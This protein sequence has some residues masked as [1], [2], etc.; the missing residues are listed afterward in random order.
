VFSVWF[1]L[2]NRLARYA[3]SGPPG[4]IQV[5][6]QRFL[7]GLLAA[8]WDA[9]LV[10]MVAIATGAILYDGLSQTQL[11]FDLFSI[12]NLSTS[13]VLLAG[14]LAIIV[15]L[16]LVVGRRVGMVAMGARLLPISVG[17]LIAHYLTYLRVAEPP[18]LVAAETRPVP[19]PERTD[20][21]SLEPTA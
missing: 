1:G 5:R 20:R 21:A 13:T 17:Y 19:T 8:R 11:S 6:R 10:T 12:P 14:F 2:L 3:R 16:T 18:A 15:G 7:D 9:S 4:S